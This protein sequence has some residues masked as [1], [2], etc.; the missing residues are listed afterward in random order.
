MNDL[1][2]LKPDELL[3]MMESMQDQLEKQHTQLETLRT[4]N[5]K[6]LKTASDLS[7]ENSTLRSELQKKS[8]TIVSLNKKLKDQC[9]I[10]GDLVKSEEAKRAGEKALKEAETIR[11][12]F[13][14]KQ[15]ELDDRE[16]EIRRKEGE[17]EIEIDTEAENRIVDARNELE[18][19]YKRKEE[20]IWHMSH[21]REQATE[22]KYKKLTV[23]YQVEFTI[24]LFY[25]VIVTALQVIATPKLME[26]AIQFISYWFQALVD[27][28]ANVIGFSHKIANISSLIPNP[29][30]SGI[31]FWVLLILISVIVIGIVYLTIYS[32]IITYVRYL[33]AN[34]FDRYTVIAAITTLA[35]T[36]FLANVIKGIAPIN[37]FAIQIGLF[38]AYSG[39]RAL[40]V[41][42]R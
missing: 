20:H 38:L 8:D 39:V 12:N 16:A 42:R 17:L 34:Q 14:C 29:T 23:R 41:S 36:I 1:K 35:F 30:A 40:V 25:S 32:L 26:G 11:S 19:E 27:L 5:Y 2:D 4:E 7:S 33:K 10:E 22:D 3:T 6:A 24:I 15:S 28:D 31:V 21:L 13:E 37:L 9:L 18:K